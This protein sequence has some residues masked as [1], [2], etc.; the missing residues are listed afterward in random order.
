MEQKSPIINA[1]T[2]ERKAKGLEKADD[3]TRSF[4]ITE[5]VLFLLCLAIFAGSVLSIIGKIS[6]N[7]SVNVPRRGG[8][9][10]EGIIGTPRFV[11]P[12]LAVSD[13]DRDLTQLV[14]SG[15]LKAQPNGNLVPDLA[16]SYTVSA[17]GL[18]YSFVIRSDA[19]FHDETSVTAADVEYTI[20]KAQDPALKSP[21]FVNWQGVTVEKTGPLTIVFH[22]KQ[23]YAPFINNLT[24]GI[25]PSHIWKNLTVDQISFSSI[26][27]NAIGSGPYI[28]S[29]ITKT[30]DGIPTQFTLT[31]NPAYTLGQP[32]INTLI[33]KS[34]SSEQGLLSAIENGTVESA[35]NLSP[36]AAQALSQKGYASSII[37]SAL[38]RVFG[39]FFNQNQDE[40]LTHKEVRKALSLIINK[41]E[42]ISSVLQGYGT[43]ADGPLPPMGGAPALIPTTASST[44]SSTLPFGFDDAAKVLT[45]AGWKKNLSTGIYELK[46]KTKG[47]ASTTLQLSISTANIPELILA[48]KKI[49]VSWKA[50]GI[51]IDVRV[52]EPTDLNQS[53]IRPRKYDALL[54]GLVTGKNSDLYPFW[55][56]SQRNDPGLN[57]ALYTNQKADKLLEKMRVA[58]SSAAVTSE[59]TQLKTELDSD[60]PAIFL[61]SPDFLYAIPAKLHGVNLGKITTSSDR[62]LG[63]EK[64]YVDTD[65]IWNVFVKDKTSIIN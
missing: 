43:A 63:V 32:Y 45:K 1:L 37:S 25:L 60:T 53:V 56:S 6:D 9:L 41:N 19:K 22:L 3:I 62:F 50:F 58:T 59:Y 18:T 64:W 23:P 54:F 12:L 48:A 20:G 44:A 4:S 16:Q 28:I 2:R 57:I 38:T 36:T 13:A 46:A 7:F 27:T 33:I 21:R 65:H 40:V 24:I 30:S 31:S 35:S 17:D 49:E 52:F 61:W 29:S 14:F 55:H 15:L 5:K 51:Q 10:V 8:Q 11:N 34:Y 26:N 42:L 47:T 39:I